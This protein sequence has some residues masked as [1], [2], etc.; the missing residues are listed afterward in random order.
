MAVTNKYT[1]IGYDEYEV[2]GNTLDVWGIGVTD[3]YHTMEQ[4]YEHRHRLFLALLKAYDGVMTPLDSCGSTV[5]CWKS[6]LHE[7]GTMYNGFFIA[8]MTKSIPAFKA[9]E[10]SITFEIAYHL[11]IRFWDIC[12]VLT[13]KN[14]PHYTGY[15][16]VDVLERLFKL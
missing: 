10:P 1:I 12:N 8:G 4:L 6:K 11:P 13:L 15:T 14:A 16:S 5:S 2:K 9:E 7:D 3:G